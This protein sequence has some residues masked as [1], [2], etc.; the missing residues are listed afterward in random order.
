M[1]DIR[2]ESVR[3]EA[4]LACKLKSQPLIGDAHS[5]EPACAEE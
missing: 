4:E 2:I 5:S 1:G 3:S